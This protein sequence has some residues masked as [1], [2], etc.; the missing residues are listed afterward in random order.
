MCIY[1]LYR[2]SLTLVDTLQTGKLRP[3]GLGYLLGHMGCNTETCSSQEMGGTQTSQLRSICYPTG[4]GRQTELPLMG[5]HW[6]CAATAAGDGRAATV[7][8]TDPAEVS[9]VDLLWGSEWMLPR[10][11]EGH[12][13]PA[14]ALTELCLPP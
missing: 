11:T 6:P 1:T 3:E 10:S 12:P 5:S 13:H 8:A 7:A 14:L 9:L 4:S 2:A